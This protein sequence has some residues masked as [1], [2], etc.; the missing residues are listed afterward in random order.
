MYELNTI[1]DFESTCSAPIKLLAFSWR[2]KKK[3]HKCCF[4]MCFCL[5][6]FI[7]IIYAMSHVIQHSMARMEYWY[8]AGIIHG[9]E[10]IDRDQFVPRNTNRCIALICHNTP[11][12]NKKQKQKNN[13]KPQKTPIKTTTTI[14]TTTKPQLLCNGQ[15]TVVQYSLEYGGKGLWLSLT[16]ERKFED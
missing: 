8:L 12:T 9:I 16:N 6:C 5:Y 14:T 10:F 15:N 3:C 4:D 11:K 7:N 1:Q 2:V 13:K